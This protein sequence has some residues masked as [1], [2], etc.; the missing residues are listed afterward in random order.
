MPWSSLVSYVEVRWSPSLHQCPLDRSRAVGLNS[1]WFGIVTSQAGFNPFLFVLNKMVKKARSHPECS[2]MFSN[3]LECSR[4][5][6]NDPECSR[7]SGMF[8]PP[9]R[10]RMVWKFQNVRESRCRPFSNVREH[11]R[12]FS[13]SSLFQVRSSVFKFVQVREAVIHLPNTSQTF[14]KWGRMQQIAVACTCTLK[15]TPNRHTLFQCVFIFLSRPSFLSLFFL[16]PH[17]CIAFASLAV[18]LV[19]P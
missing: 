5:I 9:S 1:P 18:F 6:P 3:V 16:C 15:H 11:S 10:S 4:T 19:L 8:R 17:F 12:T 13:I 14:F 2:G 7:S